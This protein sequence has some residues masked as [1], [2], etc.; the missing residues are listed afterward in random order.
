MFLEIFISHDM[1][2]QHYR[3]NEKLIF[4]ACIHGHV[5]AVIMIS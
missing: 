4:L 3:E 1:F 2:W 5:Y